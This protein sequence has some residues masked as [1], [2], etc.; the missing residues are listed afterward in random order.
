[1]RHL[2][3]AALLVAV[4]LLGVGCGGDDSSGANEGGG[5]SENSGINVEQAK[6]DLEA[7]VGGP[8]E[9]EVPELGAAVPKGKTISYVNCPVA[10][11][12]LVGEGVKEA[13]DALGWRFRNVPSDATPA[14]Y[15]QSWQQVAQNPGDGVVNV[16]ILPDSAI[17]K[18]IEQADVPIASVTSPS[19]PGP[20]VLAVIDS[21]PAV[22]RQGEAQGN[23]V[24]Q[25]AGKPVKTVFVY[26]PSLQAIS[27]AYDGYKAALTKNCP[28]CSIDVLKVSAAKIGPALAQEV[29]SH[30]Q[31][32]PDV[33]YVVFGL[34]D[35]ATG[36]PAALRGAGLADE[37]KVVVRAATP[38][39]FQD[40][41]S[42]GIAAAF[43]D[44][45]YE[46]GWRAV[47]VVLR[48]MVGKEPGDTTPF[49]LV[50]LITK[51]SLPDDIGKPYAAPGY[52]DAFKKAWG[53][54]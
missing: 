10:I 45:A 43:T 18:S 37:V 11:C 42:G 8:P 7:V 32:T 49:G 23:W 12:T 41:K 25:D 31:R 54:P 33:G 29:V 2:S 21:R 27:T 14:G 40:V 52:Q 50:R 46:A 30:L 15:R 22:Q 20:G 9:I 13:S 24:V 53:V 19:Q 17:Q 5:G 16:G 6:Q 4:A 35:L 48:A 38:P 28:E 51:E 26:D 36:V 1:V 44:E 34:G 3:M 39:N 47:D